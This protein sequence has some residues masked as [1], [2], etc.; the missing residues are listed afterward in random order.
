MILPSRA[1]L[2][3]REYSKPLTKSDWR[4]SKPI[5]T[6]Y[7]LYLHVKHLIEINNY[8]HYN[9]LYHKVLYGINCTEWY[10]AYYYIKCYG[11]SCYV[12]NYKYNV[13]KLEVDGIQDAATQYKGYII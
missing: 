4:K 12:N 10:F 7:R 13:L 6:T 5:I 3:I 1:L 9:T 8:T 11:F 2:L